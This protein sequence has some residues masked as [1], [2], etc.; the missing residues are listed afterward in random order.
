M[1]VLKVVEGTAQV[2]DM[3]IT[4]SNLQ[5]HIGGDIKIVYSEED[6]AI[7]CDMRGNTKGLKPNIV[8]CRSGMLQDVIVGTCIICGLSSEDFTGLTDAQIEK[9]LKLVNNAKTGMVVGGM[10]VPSLHIGDRV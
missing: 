1:K 3:H 4:L 9:Y 7:V 8:L 10:F 6:I 5:E 2:I